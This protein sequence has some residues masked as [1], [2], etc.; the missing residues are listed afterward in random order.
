MAEATA[1]AKKL[2]GIVFFYVNLYPDLGQHVVSTMQMVK[3]MNKPLMDKLCEDGRYVCIIAPTTKEAT[4]VEKVDYD[5]P[6][7]RYMPKSV[8]IQKV[9]LK[10]KRA[11]AFGEERLLKG[12]IT[13]Y[14]NFWP[15]VGIDTKEVLNLIRTLNQESLSA[16]AQ[17]GQFQFMIVP[18]MKEASRVEKVDLD[19][20]FPRLVPKAVEAR[21]KKINVLAPKVAVNK[22]VKRDDDDEE[23]DSD[24]NE[25][26]MELDDEELEKDSE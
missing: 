6:F 14:V 8:D 1:P 3:E 21:K 20:P 16:I 7:P 25:D 24:Q 19:D 9:G 13:L 12:F 11:Q 10:R 26:P 2:K 4:R 5:S 22:T 17:D 23:S 18:T 15:D